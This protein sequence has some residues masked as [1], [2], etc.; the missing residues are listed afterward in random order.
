M[1]R[2]AVRPYCFFF[3]LFPNVD[4]IISTGRQ[5]LQTYSVTS[6]KLGSLLFSILSDS[7]SMFPLLFMGINILWSN[8]FIILCFSFQNFSISVC[9]MDGIGR[10]FGSFCHFLFSPL[11][12]FGLFCKDMHGNLIQDPACWNSW[13][14]SGITYFESGFLSGVTG[15]PSLVFLVSRGQTLGWK[16]YVL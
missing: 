9:K 15:W 3:Y 8:N 1:C 11:L 5:L 14:E 4:L 7:V 6:N 13:A 16:V 10:Q 12:F 2:V